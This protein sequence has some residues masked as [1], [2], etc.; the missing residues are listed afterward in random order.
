MS[1]SAKFGVAVMA[2]SVYVSGVQAVDVQT[3]TVG[4]PDNAG[5]NSGE[6]EPGGDG[7][8]RICGTVDYVY[9][10]DTFE[11]TAG[12]Y[13]AFLNAVAATGRWRFYAIGAGTNGCIC[14]PTRSAGMTA[15]TRARLGQA[16]QY[17]LNQW[18]ALC[19]RAGK[20]GQ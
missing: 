12:Q 17:A 1:G 6:S 2:V 18:D 15:S 20:T 10:I 7:S 14:R 16:I 3:A 11:V 8:D 9:R 13:T 19:Q 5:E 4:N